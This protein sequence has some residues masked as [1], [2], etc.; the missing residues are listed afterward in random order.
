MLWFTGQSGFYGRLDPKVGKA[1]VFPAPKGR[2]P[3]GI[4]ATPGG[5]IY[6]VSLAG[7]HMAK[8]ETSSGQVEVLEPLTQGQGARRVWSDSQGRVW[9]SEWLA[10]K[11]G[12]YD[13]QTQAWKEWPL[14]GEGPQP[15]A[16]YVD[17]QDMVWL[18]DFRANAMV[19]FDPASETFNVFT[20]PSPSA[21]VR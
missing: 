6:Y 1:E 18:S 20:L 4:A 11:L 21:S 13:P 14:P 17:D 8:V 2:G 7:S 10:G 3:Y 9:V 16:V 19:R 15:Y 5:E 12:M